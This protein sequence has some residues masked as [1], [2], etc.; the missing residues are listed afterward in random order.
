MI[1]IGLTGGLASGKSTVAEMLRARGVPVIDAD[2]LAKQILQGEARAAVLAEFGNGILSEDGVAI[3][4]EKLAAVVFAAGAEA[5][6]AAL[7]RILHP[8]TIKAQEAE[9]RRLEAAGA[10]AAA[11]EAALLLEAG[12][13]ESFDKLVVVA[14]PEEERIRRFCERTGASRERALERLQAQW[15]QERKIAHADYVIRNGGTRDAT[16][17]QVEAMLKELVP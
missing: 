11:V 15:P 2:A 5:K 6:L 10:R 1:R 8:R 7:N 16:R 3:A 12:A 13:G 17:E 4:S 14:A 9:L